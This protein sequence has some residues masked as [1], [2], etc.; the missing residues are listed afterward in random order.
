MSD[1]KVIETQEQFDEMLGD[2]LKRE[3]ESAER[4]YVHVKTHG[5]T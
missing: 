5:K 2:R 4:K 1:F 3:R